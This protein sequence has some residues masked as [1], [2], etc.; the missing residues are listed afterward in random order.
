MLHAKNLPLYL[1]EE[2]TAT[3][4]YVKNRTA[5]NTLKGKTPYKMYEEKTFLSHLKV[6]GCSCYVHIAKELRSKWEMNSTKMMMVGYSKSNKAYRVYDPAARKC[7]IRRDVILDEKSDTN[8]VIIQSEPTRDGAESDPD[9]D[10][11]NTQDEQRIK[12]HEPRIGEM[13]KKTIYKNP[14]API[15][16]DLYPLRLQITSTASKKNIAEIKVAEALFTTANA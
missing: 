4:V 3:A 9:D 16:R 12:K 6:F 1:W 15:E 2:A 13:Q 10:A 11:E 8:D 5:T 7:Y 14:R